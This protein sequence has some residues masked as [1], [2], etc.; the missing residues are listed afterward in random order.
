MASNRLVYKELSRR[1]GGSFS[2]M[3]VICP[4][5]HNTD[6]GTLISLLE[7]EMSLTNPQ[8]WEMDGKC[9]QI[10]QVQPEGLAVF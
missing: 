3:L 7:A 10:H 8:G 6:R 2:S 1:G 4:P 5:A 9:S